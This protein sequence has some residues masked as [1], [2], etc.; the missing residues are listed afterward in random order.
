MGGREIEELRKRYPCGA[1]VALGCMDDLW[2]P[3]V[4]TKGTVLHVDDMGTIHV[5]WDNGSCLGVV[6]GADKCHVIE[7]E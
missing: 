7:E 4:G 5:R 2:A 6:Y 1:R 3:P